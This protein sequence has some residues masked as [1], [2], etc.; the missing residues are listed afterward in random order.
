MPPK[1][2]KKTT[3]QETPVVSNLAKF[4]NPNFEKYFLKL[5]ETVVNLVV[6]EFYA[7][8]RDQEIRK[9]LSWDTVTVR[10]KEVSI[11]PRKIC[12]FY[13]VPFY[14]KD[15]LNNIDLDKLEDIDMEDVIKY[16]TQDRGT[17]NHRLDTSFP[18][19]F[20]PVI[21]FPR[22]QICVGRWIYCEMRHCTQSEKPRI[23]FPHLEKE[24]CGRAEVPMSENEQFMK[25]TR[26][27]IRDSL[28]TKY[29]E[30][31]R[32]QI[33]NWNQ[34]RKE[35]LDVLMSLKRKEQS[36]ARKGTSASTEEKIDGM[37]KWMQE[38]EAE[39]EEETLEAEVEGDTQN[40][41]RL[42]D[43]N[44]E[45][46]MEEAQQLELSMNNGGCTYQ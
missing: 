1:K 26:S 37:I 10:G 6:Q 12:E 13:D 8:F 31:Q 14:S 27:I 44:E 15:F 18:T 43:E 42:E 3:V 16:L 7:S 2:S 28:Y 32:K 36:K 35:K 41:P 34:R 30:L 24:L 20:D 22:K 38:M 4:E 45:P 5:Q 19:N 39:D 25:P 9:R 33:M 23:F 29:V 11:T 46:F 17:W 40:L 21:M